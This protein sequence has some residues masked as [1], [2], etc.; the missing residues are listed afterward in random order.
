[1]L[2]IVIANAET[3]ITEIP[4]PPE[5]VRLASAEILQ[6]DIKPAVEPKMNR[7]LSY[8]ESIELSEQVRLFKENG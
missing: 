3:Y 7:W 8:T 4:D 5:K 6:H 1:M 2:L